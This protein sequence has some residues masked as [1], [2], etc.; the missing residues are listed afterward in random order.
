MVMLD[1]SMDNLD[2]FVNN[3]KTMMDTLATNNKILTVTNAKLIVTN[4]TYSAS[5]ITAKPPGS[6]S[7]RNPNHTLQHKSCKKWAI[8]G[9]FLTH[10]WEVLACHNI[11][12]FPESNPKPVHD[13]ATMRENTKGPSAKSNKGWDAWVFGH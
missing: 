7:A 12:T 11:K 5:G 3:N 10:D 9:F 4:A 13:E 6:S 2:S 1:N 8:G